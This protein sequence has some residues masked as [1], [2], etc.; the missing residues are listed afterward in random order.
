MRKVDRRL[1]APYIVLCG[2]QG[3]GKSTLAEAIKPNLEQ[4]LGKE[5]H[6]IQGVGR[7][8]KSKGFSIDKDATLES[9]WAI[10]AA[11]LDIETRLKHSPK[12]FCRSVID[13]FAYAR[14]NNQ[15]FEIYFQRIVPTTIQEYHLLIYVP[16][17]ESVPLVDDG[18]RN[19]DVEYQKRV[20]AQI[21][22]ILIEYNVP[23]QVVL[24][25]VEQ[26]LSA[27]MSAIKLRLGL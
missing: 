8:V 25:T 7:Q 27:A 2:A 24:G 10:E 23:V 12:L 17:E 20:D 13:R 21:R 11:Y 14:A 6:L 22:Q 4:L 15:D 16:I 5:V 9:K 26:R 19:T 3:T 1:D 18:L